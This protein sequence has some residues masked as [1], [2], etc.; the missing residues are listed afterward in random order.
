MVSQDVLRRQVLRVRDSPGNPAVALIDQVARFALGR[1]MHA[2]VEDIL[3]A[4][5]YGSML[6]SLRADP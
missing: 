1:G 2:V 6:R 5:I 3:Y 4:D